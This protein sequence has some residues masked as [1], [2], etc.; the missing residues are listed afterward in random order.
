MSHIH[1]TASTAASPLSEDWVV[2]ER[3]D[4]SQFEVIY[5][6]RG[7]LKH[8]FQEA[9]KAPLTSKD[10][11]MLDTIII[12][13]KDRD[14]PSEAKPITAK[15]QKVHK[16]LQSAFLPIEHIIK[17]GPLNQSEA[18]AEAQKLFDELPEE[19]HP[20]VDAFF[21]N[22]ILSTEK[23]HHSFS[24]IIQSYTS[25]KTETPNPSDLAKIIDLQNTYGLP[26]KDLA[27]VTY[28]Q[29]GCQRI[30]YDVDGK[31]Q[32]GTQ[33]DRISRSTESIIQGPILH[34]EQ[35]QHIAQIYESN[36]VSRPFNNAIPLLE[37]MNFY[38]NCQKANKRLTL[39]EAYASFRPDPL[40]MFQKYKGGNCVIVSAQ[41]RSELCTSGYQNFQV[42][43]SSENLATSLP[44][45]SIDDELGIPWMEHLKVAKNIAHVET[46]IPFQTADGK[47][48]AI[49]LTTG[50]QGRNDIESISCTS[51][52]GIKQYLEE[53]YD[54]EGTSPIESLD[55]I[56]KKRLSGS[57][58]LIIKEPGNPNSIFGIDLLQGNIFLSSEAMRGLE[59][60]LPLSNTGK[61]SIPLEGLANGTKGI[62]TVRGAEKNVLHAVAFASVIEKIQGRFQ[63]PEDIKENILTLAKK[64][65]AYFD[66]IAMK[67]LALIK[68]HL[69]QI[70]D[71]NRLYHAIYEDSSARDLAP[72][73]FTA[74]QDALKN[75]HR[76]LDD[77]DEKA[78]CTAFDA[79]RRHATECTE[80]RAS[81]TD[82]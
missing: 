28:A 75:I 46:I 37:F 4:S 45:V 73:A 13:G 74:L 65:P 68:K 23:L 49:A 60:Q 41:I 19:E 62:Y 71:V 8:L 61:V 79:F 53:K 21:A 64:L 81:S 56:L 72:D 39:S 67:P 5:C 16:L 50:L 47:H 55:T 17:K 82:C 26:R 42:S 10:H 63:L 18:I 69:R 32:M 51:K 6:S 38:K 70:E 58:K 27:G 40:E 3:E 22:L 34:M 43:T 48:C 12:N 25:M 30:Y 36:A 31:L 44:I 77:N 66:E 9:V 2:I 7:G 76:A 54:K 24:H 59:A 35:L 29:I 57:Y 20:A 11:Q 14:A 15:A 80:D 78:L 1:P 52:E 33:M